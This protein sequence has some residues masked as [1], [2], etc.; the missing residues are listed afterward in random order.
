MSVE[1][2]Q[3]KD[4]NTN[5]V[6]VPVTHWDAVANKPDLAN[7]SPIG[8]ISLWPLST[9]P[10]GWLL[11]N[12][13]SIATGDQYAQLRQV[14]NANIVPNYTPATIEDLNTLLMNNDNNS[15]NNDTPQFTL[16][17]IIRYM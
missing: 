14:L 13:Q 3:L 1:I 7:V 6:F 10:N 8:S 12:G 2:R 15:G 9:P 11:C 16:R 5:T 4:K 17:F